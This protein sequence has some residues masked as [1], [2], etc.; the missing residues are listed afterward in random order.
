MMLDL[1]EKF[2]KV[3]NGLNFAKN[4]QNSGWELNLKKDK[5]YY[6]ELDKMPIDIISNKEQLSFF[7][8]SNII[9]SAFIIYYDEYGNKIDGQSCL[10]YR[11]LK[12]IIP[13]NATHFVAAIRL[14]NN[15]E[16]NLHSFLIGGK[17]DIDNLIFKKF[18]FDDVEIDA[19]RINKQI[20][21]ETMF[22]DVERDENILNR[23]F[24]YLK[25]QIKL[26]GM[27]EVCLDDF[28]WVIHV[29]KDKVEYINLLNMLTKNIKNIYINVYEHKN[30]NISEESKI[31]LLKKPNIFGKN[32]DNIF[33]EF[34]E[35]IN[36]KFDNKIVVRIGLDD[37]DFIS[38]SHLN[39]INL[40]VDKYFDK[41]LSKP[42]VFIGFVDLNIAYHFMDGTSRVDSIIM[43][44]CM[45]GNRF[46][47]A[48]LNIPKS[49]FSIT[50]DFS[51]YIN[52]ENS[53]Y[54]IFYSESPTFYYNRHG[55]NLSRNGKSNYYMKLMNQEYFVSNKE[56]IK[57]II[58]F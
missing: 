6:I 8:D 38:E 13:I 9:C 40:A 42:E 18:S 5:P 56:F 1:K 4:L 43:S 29:S 41:I 26:I 19:V 24:S 54:F 20:I 46:S 44:K 30:Y 49:P 57:S 3:L 45:T 51:E 31:D 10:N 7:C 14:K 52:K 53:E 22:C 37:D 36:Y 33:K 25:T 47:A 48:Y 11:S 50:E 28:L 55:I 32:Y 2:C 34:L 27:W 12:L 17:P 16:L 23:Y 15:N 39:K 35:K 21:M 58:K